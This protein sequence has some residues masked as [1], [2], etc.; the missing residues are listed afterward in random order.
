MNLSALHCFADFFFPALQ[1]IVHMG[2]I[3][4]CLTQSETLNT[5][6]N[7]HSLRSFSILP[8]QAAHACHKYLPSL[9]TL[10]RICMPCSLS[11]LIAPSML[12]PPFLRILSIVHFFFYLYYTRKK[13]KKMNLAE[14]VH[15]QAELDQIYPISPYTQ[16]KF[17]RIVFRI[18]KKG[19]A[20][21]SLLY[22]AYVN[23]TPRC[24]LNI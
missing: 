23:A 16:T 19:R 1:H 5:E 21:E 12:S 18:L 4:F 6:I 3:P 2:I 17:L 11:T 10:R 20:N 15:F 22:L 7:F 14:L 24:A 9:H 13:P 8:A